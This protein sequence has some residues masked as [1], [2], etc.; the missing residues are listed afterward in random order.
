MMRI[1]PSSSAVTLRWSSRMINA[2]DSLLLSR[3]VCD[4]MYEDFENQHKDNKYKNEEVENEINIKIKDLNDYCIIRSKAVH[5][6][7]LVMKKLLDSY[8]SSVMVQ[9]TEPIKED[10]KIKK[11]KKVENVSKESSEGWG[12]KNKSKVIKYILIIFKLFYY[13]YNFS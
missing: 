4:E 3:Q 1:L 5:S 11:N 10:Y 2:I 9:K 6:K 13:I 7:H 12:K 8:L